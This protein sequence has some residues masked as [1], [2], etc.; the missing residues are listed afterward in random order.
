MMMTQFMEEQEQM[1]EDEGFATPAEANED[2]QRE[3]AER[4]ERYQD[5]K[6]EAMLKRQRRI[7]E[8]DRDEHRHR[9]VTPP[10]K[11]PKTTAREEAAVTAR[12]DRKD[13]ATQK[14]KKARQQA[15]DAKR[16][17]AAASITEESKEEPATGA[18][19]VF[20]E[21]PRSPKEE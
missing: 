9:S 16:Q 10:R 4:H 7:A 11:D 20:R 5:N 14:A 8:Q 2:A 21:A 13:E 18:E 15:M 1:E 3:A 19:P 6:A 17:A 12:N